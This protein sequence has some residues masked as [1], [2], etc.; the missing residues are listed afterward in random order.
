MSKIVTD[1]RRT[2]TALSA[3]GPLGAPHEVAT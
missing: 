3:N 1:P 2:N